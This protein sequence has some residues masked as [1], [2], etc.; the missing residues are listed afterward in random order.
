MDKPSV[1]VNRLRTPE[2]RKSSD[3]VLSATDPIFDTDPLFDS[4]NDDDFEAD[5]GY[6]TSSEY[7]YVVGSSSDEGI[8]PDEEAAREESCPRSDFIIRAM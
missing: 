2:E 4:E 7:E 1:W 6:T 5:E 8:V 3:I